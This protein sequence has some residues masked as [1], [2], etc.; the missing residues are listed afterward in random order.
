MYKVIKNFCS[1]FAYEPIVENS[2][3]L[4]KYKKFVVVG[5]GGSNLVTGL[6]RLWKPEIAIII[7]RDYGLPILPAAVWGET[8]VIASSYSGNTEETLDG[9]TVAG[10][11][12]LAR[13][14]ITVGG[15]L[16]WGA[17]RE[18][19]PYIQLPDTG[20]QPRSAMGFSFLALLKLVGDKKDLQ[21]VRKLNISLRSDDFEGAGR[22][23]AQKLKSFVPIIYSST[24][25]E[26]I[27]HNWKVRFNE[28]GKIPAFYNVFPELNHNEMTGFDPASLVGMNALR[29]TQPTKSAGFGVS[30]ERKKL[31]KLFHFIFLRDDD[32]DPRI[33]KRMETTA[34]LYKNINFP[35]EVLKLEGKNQLL[36]IFS[37]LVLA[38]W[39]A[40]YTAVEYGVEPEQ[41]PMVEKFKK[42]MI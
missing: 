1:Q 37:S 9:F 33:Q 8:L 30:T 19:V 20:I 23:L 32:D 13:A 3:Q 18:G 28:T 38:D 11:N 24:R 2:G 22:K 14:V 6:L 5:M 36:K 31:Q 7:H 4:G 34:E 41:V 17:K 10:E 29:E 15:K 35:V 21:E 40:Y 26:A 27:A 42:L 25:N 39:V 16:L 12:G